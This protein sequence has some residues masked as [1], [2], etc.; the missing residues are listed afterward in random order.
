MRQMGDLDNL[1]KDVDE[2]KRRIDDNVKWIRWFFASISVF[3]GFIFTGFGLY[4]AST[5]Q[6]EQQALIDFRDYVEKQLRLTVDDASIQVSLADPDKHPVTYNKDANGSFWRIPFIIANVGSSTVDIIL[7]KLYSDKPIF[8]DRN[9]SED[10]PAYDYVGYWT[11]EEIASKQIPPKAVI[12][13]PLSA[14][15][16]DLNT[17]YEGPANVLAKVYYGKNQPLARIPS[18]STLSTSILL[19]RNHPFPSAWWLSAW[20]L[21]E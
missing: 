14:R 16:D 15:I 21:Y 20:W 2:Q 19:Q 13:L 8:K 4:T 6:R 9:I 3:L 12:D 1:R 11:P 10:E 7:V 5:L 18:E 17:R